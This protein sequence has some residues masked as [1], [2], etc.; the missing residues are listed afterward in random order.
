MIQDLL[1][2]GTAYADADAD[3]NLVRIKEF[4]L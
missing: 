3:N 1:V 2:N 4:K